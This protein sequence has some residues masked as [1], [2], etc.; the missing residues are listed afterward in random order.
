MSND[1]ARITVPKF[2]AMKA[3]GRKITM[4]TAYDYAMAG[5]VD[6]AGIEGILVGDSLS[7]VV[8][9]HDTTLPVTLDEMIYHA[10]MVG[11]AVRARAG[12]RR[13]AVSQLPPGHAQGDRKRRP[14]SQGNP[15]PG[16]EAR[17]RRRAGRG[18]RGAGVGRHS[19]HGPLRTAAAERPPAGRLPRAA[20]RASNCWPTP[21]PPRLPA[22]SPSC[23]SAFPPTSPREITAAV[24]IPTIGIG[25][26]AGCDGQVLVLHDLLGLTPGRVP[27]HVKAYADLRQRQSSTPSPATATKSAAACSPDPSRRFRNVSVQPSEIGCE[28]MTLF[29]NIEDLVS[30]S[31]VEQ[32]LIWQI[33]TS[34]PPL[35]LAYGT[36]QSTKANIL[37]LTIGKGTTSN[38]IFPIMQSSSLAFPYSLSSETTGRGHGGSVA[39]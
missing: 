18:D 23:W 31:D 1:P 21:R 25:A 15:L 5:L 32:K 30:E 14:D 27:R 12:R 38:S 19:G 20:R 17:R 16:R 22:R 24:Q 28:T 13:H 26:G 34:L 11:R 35:G 10:E 7:M 29:C 36:A 9:G 33:L 37:A 8:Q 4:L 2:A 6:A 39:K 3:A